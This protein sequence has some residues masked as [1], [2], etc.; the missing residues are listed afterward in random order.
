MAYAARLLL[1]HS[2]LRYTSVAMSIYMTASIQRSGFEAEEALF[3]SSQ[4]IVIRV[5]TCHYL[6]PP[7]M[8]NLL[9]FTRNVCNVNPGL[10][11]PRLFNWGGTIY[12]PS[13]VTIW[14]VPPN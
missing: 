6:I 4:V 5:T 2:S 12:V 3:L 11:T 13:K 10:I 7:K 8:E 1:V 14:R 9:Q